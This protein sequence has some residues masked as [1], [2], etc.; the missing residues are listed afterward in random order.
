MMMPDLASS[1][2]IWYRLDAVLLCAAKLAGL[3]PPI[4]LS[5]AQFAIQG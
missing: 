5:G 2:K 1:S 4:E 3:F